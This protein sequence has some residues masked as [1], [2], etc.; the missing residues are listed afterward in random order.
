VTIYTP[1]RERIREFI[2]Q[3]EQKCIGSHSHSSSA[4]HGCATWRASRRRRRRP[5]R[6]NHLDVALSRELR[7]NLWRS[8]GQWAERMGMQI[9]GPALRKYPTAATPY[10]ERRW[11]YLWFNMDGDLVRRWLSRLTRMI[12][13]GLG[14]HKDPSPC[15]K[16][17]AGEGGWA[18]TADRSSR[19]PFRET[20]V[21]T[22]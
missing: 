1:G 13:E 5:S 2:A 6:R 21:P 14:D 18:L 15:R 19:D 22:L 3:V 16:R 10:D 11:C 8:A 7:F 20:P 9:V 4:W 17:V 12:G